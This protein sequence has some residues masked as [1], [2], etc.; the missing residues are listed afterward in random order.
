MPIITETERLLLRTWETHDAEAVFRIWG[1]AEAMRWVD[2]GK[3]SADV[4]AVR[5]GLAVGQRCQE[6]NGYCLW[7][8]VERASGEVVGDCG[9]IKLDD[10]PGVEL[11]YHLRRDVWGRGYATE[12]AGACLRYA[13]EKMGLPAVHAWAHPKNL[14]SKRVLGKLGFQFVAMDEGEERFRLGRAERS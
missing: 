2:D 8:V 3:V 10:E 9:F 13:F 7:A 4:E 11:G 1:D 6:E 12:A 5:R 14:A